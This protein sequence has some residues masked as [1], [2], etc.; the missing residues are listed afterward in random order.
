MGEQQWHR[1]RLYVAS[2]MCVGGFGFSYC[3]SLPYSVTCVKQICQW[4]TCTKCPT[5]DVYVNS[6]LQLLHNNTRNELYLLEGVSCKAAAENVL[7]A[8]NRL[9]MLVS[10]CTCFLIL[11]H[12][13]ICYQFF[14]FN[15]YL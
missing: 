4:K 10:A 6:T 9:H 11:A 8:A 12:L 5:I 1:K 15:S 14:C 3:S 13:V 7:F 2:L